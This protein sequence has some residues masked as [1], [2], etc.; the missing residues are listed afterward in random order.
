[1]MGVMALAAAEPLTTAALLDLRRASPD[2]AARTAALSAIYGLGG[3]QA[4]A[5]AGVGDEVVGQWQDEH[6]RAFLAAHDG[7]DDRRRFDL[8]AKQLSAG[9]GMVLPFARQQPVDGTLD[10]GVRFDLAGL[11]LSCERIVFTLDED[12]VLGRILRRAEISAGATVDTV[13]MDSRA[14]VLAMVNMRGVIEQGGL[15]IERVADSDDGVVRYVLQGSDLRRFTGAVRNDD[16]RW[17][18]LQA[19][20]AR[21]EADVIMRYDASGLADPQLTEVRL[22]GQPAE[23][24]M[25]DGGQRMAL[26]SS[27]LTIAFTADGRVDAVRTGA[28]TTV[29]GAPQ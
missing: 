14:A 10:G 23:L 6:L 22:F 3:E 1:M 26:G 11:H 15:V 25:V 8:A 19:R 12:P 2:A 17:A 21:F 4:V 9:A 28:D 16:G 5:V 13:V 18:P 27:E 24:E 29:R 7:A 20:A